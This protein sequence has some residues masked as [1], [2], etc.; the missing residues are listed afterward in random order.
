MGTLSKMAT[1]RGGKK[2]SGR[3]GKFCR[4]GQK[5]EGQGQ[6]RDGFT[7]G[8]VGV[9]G[10]WK[11]VRAV[12][13]EKACIETCLN[14]AQKRVAAKS[15]GHPARCCPRE[16]GISAAH[17]RWQLGLCLLAGFQGMLRVTEVRNLTV[18]D[19]SIG[20]GRAIPWG[21]PKEVN[22]RLAP[23]SLRTRGWL[24]CWG[25]FVGANC[26]TASFWILPPERSTGTSKLCWSI[27]VCRLWSTRCTVCGMEVQR[28]LH[29]NR[30][31]GVWQGAFGRDCRQP[32]RV[33]FKSGAS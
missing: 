27:S 5:V 19:V 14:L 33:S 8:V 25:C 4:A 31:T 9:S 26:A 11:E 16:G 23:N 13:S 30:L 17:H 29:G 28:F 18:C 2:E 3:A 24:T 7:S 6:E 22:V 1:E 21:F 20:K 15:S 12:C 10:D 32:P